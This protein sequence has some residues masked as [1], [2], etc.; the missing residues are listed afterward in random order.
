MGVAGG[1]ASAAGEGYEVMQ[2]FDRVSVLVKPATQKAAQDNL[3]N[4]T[5]LKAMGG[6]LPDDH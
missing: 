3:E 2:G 6:G 5:L 1:V 4:N